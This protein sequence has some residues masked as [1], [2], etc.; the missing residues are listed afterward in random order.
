MVYLFYCKEENTGVN[1]YA[2]VTTPR[3]NT[4][5]RPPFRDEERHKHSNVYHVITTKNGIPCFP[6]HKAVRPAQGGKNENTS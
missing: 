5:D 2:E 1:N 3:V 6:T 4:T